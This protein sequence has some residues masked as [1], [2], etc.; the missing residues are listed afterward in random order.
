MGTSTTESQSIRKRHRS[1]CRGEVGR[2]RGAYNLLLHV[3]CIAAV[4]NLNHDHTGGESVAL[5]SGV[6]GL[7]M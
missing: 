7:S 6:K 2:R 3:K 1:D 5:K 4:E